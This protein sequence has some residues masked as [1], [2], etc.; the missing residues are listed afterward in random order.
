MLLK[1]DEQF[2]FLLAK[3]CQ[4]IILDMPDVAGFVQKRSYQ[5]LPSFLFGKIATISGAGIPLHWRNPARIPLAQDSQAFY[6]K[7]KES[8]EA[9]IL[10]VVWQKWSQKKSN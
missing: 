6:K 4:W 7:D 2:P 9:S 5:A 1:G 3:L 10:A 8:L